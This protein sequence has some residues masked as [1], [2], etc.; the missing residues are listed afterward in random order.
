MAKGYKK[1]ESEN[2]RLREASIAILNKKE[3]KGLA[4][5]H[6]SNAEGLIGVEKFLK[7]LSFWDTQSL[8]QCRF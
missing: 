2:E 4:M 3:N 5:A 8:S 1:L 7:G 6:G